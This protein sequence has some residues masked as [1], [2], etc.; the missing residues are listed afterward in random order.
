[1][2][3]ERERVEAVIA[4]PDGRR[5]NY[6]GHTV[7]DQLGRDVSRLWAVKGQ[8]QRMPRPDSQER[9]NRIAEDPQA[10]ASWILTASSFC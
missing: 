3:L 2:L 8:A 10:E 9:G 7:A 5:R 4:L 6:D 1:M